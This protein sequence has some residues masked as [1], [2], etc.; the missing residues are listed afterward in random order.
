MVDPLTFEAFGFGINQGWL[1]FR[2][3]VACSLGWRTA[4]A[5]RGFRARDCFGFVQGFEFEVAQG[6]V[7]GKFRLLQFGIIQASGFRVVQRL[8]LFTV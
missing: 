8:W 4:E 5:S 2:V 3:W 1:W 7:S 6:L